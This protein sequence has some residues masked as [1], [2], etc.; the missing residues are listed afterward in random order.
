ML[1]SI[2]NHVLHHD[3]DY[4]LIFKHIPVP[5]PDIVGSV[6]F[7]LKIPISPTIAEH[8]EII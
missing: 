1:Y 7:S 8:D 6:V 3:H 5:N 2:I 4:Y